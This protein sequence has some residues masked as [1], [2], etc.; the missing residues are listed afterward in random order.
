M[1]VDEGLNEE[2]CAEPGHLHNYRPKQRINVRKGR[3][4][5]YLSPPREEKEADLKST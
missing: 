5:T 2:I 3:F 4:H 1:T